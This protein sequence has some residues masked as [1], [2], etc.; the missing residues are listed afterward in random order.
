MHVAWKGRF[1]PDPA[2]PP[3]TLARVQAQVASRLARAPRFRRRLAF[4]PG[5]FAHPV[6]VDAEDFDMRRHVVALAGDDEP[7]AR[8]RASTRSPTP[9][10]RARSTA[11]TRCG[12]SISRRASRTGRVGL[13]MKIHHALVDGKS[14]LAS[15]CCC[16]TSTRTRPSRPRRRSWA[17]GPGARRGAAR[18][19]RARGLRH[20]AAAGARPRRARGRIAGPAGR[21]AAPGGDGG[22]RG[23][24]A[25]G[26]VLVPQ[27]PDRPAA[28]ARRPLAA[29]RASCSRSSAPA[30]LAQRR[31][32]RRGR[33]R[34]APARA[35][36]A[37]RARAAQ[38][39][40]ARVAPRRAARR[41]RWATASP[42]SSSR[43]R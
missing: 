16:S 43:C 11:R 12:R 42:S 29:G 20:R 21:H 38:G 40:G 26:A 34:A 33:R 18:G 31:R 25:P 17:G 22:R 10:S 1:R 39:D 24:R 37:R 15:R 7:L 2:R 41:P 3:I 4:P 35:A 13:V 8:A 6:W 23:R 14:A 36:A 9:R 28:H 19:R 30:T 27:R 32:A 5:G